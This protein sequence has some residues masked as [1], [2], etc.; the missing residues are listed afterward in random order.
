[1]SLQHVIRAKKGGRTTLMKKGRSSRTGGS[2]EKKK[3]DRQ[4][5]KITIAGIGPFH[6]NVSLIELPSAP[7]YHLHT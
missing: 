4:Q 3:L 7:D 5:G 2:A 1:M 6:E